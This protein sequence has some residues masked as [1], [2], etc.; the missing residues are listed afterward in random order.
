MSVA[1]FTAHSAKTFRKIQGLT[2][3][4]SQQDAELEQLIARYIE[5]VG[6]NRP[7]TDAAVAA[8]D[9]FIHVVSGP[10]SGSLYNVCEFVTGLAS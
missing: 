8:L 7:L 5:E 4:I 3:L 9:L 6:G 1:A 2:T 10:Y